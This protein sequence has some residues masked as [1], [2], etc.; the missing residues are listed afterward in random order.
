[1]PAG[2]TWP[3][4][5]RRFEDPKTGVPIL[6]LTNH[7]C[8]SFHPYFTNPG[9]W[10]EG[11]RLILASHRGNAANLYSCELET[12][13]LRQLTDF[14]P[15]GG[16]RSALIFVNP[17]RDEV[18]FV[19]GARI[20]ALDLR[21]LRQRVL[22]EKPEGFR[23]GSLS[24]TADGTR[25]CTVV[26]EDLSSRI[27]MDLGHGYVGFAEYSA[28]RPLSKVLAVSVD[29]GRIDLVHEERFWIGHVNTSPTLPNVLTFCHEGPWDKVDQR[30]WTLDVASRQ[31]APLR[32]QSPG[33]NLGHEYWFADGE[34]VGY[35]GWGEG[36]ESP[37][38]SSVAGC[39]SHRFGWVRWDG[40]AGEEYRFP[41]GS[42]HFHSLD[43]ELIVG[44]GGGERREL[45]LWRL[46]DG[47]YEGPRTLAVHRGSFHVQILHVHPRMFAGRDGQIRVLYSADPQGYGNVYVADVPEFE[48]LP[49]AE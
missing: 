23:L 20:L 16:V 38:P 10:D 49:E 22:F 41:H 45:L 46:R 11:R 43:E 24:C 5:S 2:D 17:K 3:S 8:H 29:D 27:R 40:S 25:I 9:L 47:E 21:T 4:E 36:P 44:D 19:E 28:A 18:Y 31:A 15:D 7:R 32:K 35:H 1:M 13:E 34:R 39:P 26:N 37:P 48:S 30:M 42:T 12:G 6:Q 14:G 33:E